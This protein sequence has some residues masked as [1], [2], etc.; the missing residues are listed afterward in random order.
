MFDL[1]P[2]PADLVTALRL[3]ALLHPERSAIEFLGDGDNVTERLSYG[4]LDQR[5]Q[6][7]AAVLQEAAAPG[8]RAL[9]LF[10]T[11]PDYVIAFF[12]CLYAGVVAV[13]LYPPETGQPQAVK[14]LFNVAEDARPA[15]ALTDAAGL[16]AVV[17]HQLQRPGMRVLVTPQCEGAPGAWRERTARS[18]ELAFLQYTS[19]STATPKG[20]MVRHEH[21]LANH[22]ALSQ[23]MDE[24]PGDRHFSWLPLFHDMGL[25]FGL[26][27]PLLQGSTL[28]L[29]SPKRFIE[30]PRRW[31]EAVS[32]HRIRLSGGPDFAYRLCADRVRPASVA[33]LD[34]S[35]WEVAYCGAEPVRQS[36][37]EAFCQ[38]ATPLGFRGRAFRPSYG[39]AEATLFVSAAG[40][41]DQ[42]ADMFDTAALALGRA[43]PAP[44]GTSL[45]ACGAPAGGTQVRIVAP[46]TGAVLPEG[47][48]GE[49]WVQGPTVAGGYWGHGAATAASFAATDAEGHGP[50]LR[51]GDLG[52][53]H[54]GQ[55]YIS[56]RLKDLVILRGRNH[57][58]QDIELEIELRVPGVRP[59]RVAVFAAEVNDAETIGVAAEVARVK[60]GEARHAEVIEA[61]RQA[62]AE[63]FGEPAGAIALLKPGTL[64]KT[65]SG[66]LRRSACRDGWR[67]GSLQTLA[68]YRAD[69][70]AAAPSS[71]AVLS[72]DTERQLAT[73]WAELLDLD[74]VGAHDN[75]FALG[76]QSL[77]MTQLAAR[78]QTDFGVALP[79]AACF[80]AANLAELARRIDEAPRV[81][82]RAGLQPRVRSTA[83]T[84]LLPLSYAQRRLWFLQSLEPT[85]AFYHVAIGLA[86]SGP[87]DP[88]RWQAALDALVQ[89]HEVLRTVFVEAAADPCQQVLPDMAVPLMQ[90]DAEDE[91]V[92]RRLVRQLLAVPFDLTR[93]P[94]L[95]ALL[96]DAAS[97]RPRLVLVMHHIAVDG[98]ALKPL[99][100]DLAL[101]YAGAELAPVPL[102]YA[103]F[104]L[105]QQAELAP[106]LPALVEAWRAQLLDAPVLT[107]LPPDLPRPPAQTHAGASLHRQL[108]PALVEALDKWARAERATLFMALFAAYA[109]TLAEASGQ[110]DLVIGTDIA[111]RHEPGTESIVGFFVNQLPVRCRVPSAAGATAWLVQVRDTLLAAYTLQDLPFDQLVEALRP[112]RTLAH[113][114]VF[115]TKFVF[116]DAPSTHSLAPG[117]SMQPFD[118]PR[119]SAELDLLFDLSRG[120]EGVAVR[121]EYAAD[122]YRSDT[123]ARFAARFIARLEAWVAKAELPSPARRALV[124]RA[125]SPVHSTTEPTR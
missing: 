116:Q 12:A 77:L 7:L 71:A 39:L 99:L 123:V 30:R 96:L 94:L 93:G 52:F 107:T 121:I 83:D 27:Q 6:A 105:W 118:I 24:Q 48:V 69:G 49:I 92:E 32:R 41:Q 111:N 2:T 110:T 122:L 65:S 60:T 53:I 81:P 54:A 108:S 89:R 66:K 98:A 51:T 42:V 1:H 119:E 112:P 102:Q 61:I 15:L 62:V 18:D 125:A 95:R 34:L 70:P 79:L 26:L 23:G 50:C 85:S 19:G 84:T 100:A 106:R 74:Q 101:H 117:L 35:C 28:F 5:A 80:T 13:P 114:P 115:Q 113:A 36:T 10:P 73:L 14:R 31:L 58:P 86:F 97:A 44:Q 40:G 43:E 9:L 76:G 109:A 25:I 37:F 38:L 90:R 29:M 104:T 22:H 8:E 16:E 4:Q 82:V 63:A 46:D 88:A 3:R 47:Q 56:S 67:D 91:Q 20:V 55:L 124:R 68:L 103:D 72:T 64:P 78:V 59:G 11:G 87:V 57:Y 75:F 17:Q 33:G 45:V 120:P 21:L